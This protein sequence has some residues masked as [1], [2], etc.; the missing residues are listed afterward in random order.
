MGSPIRI[1]AERDAGAGVIR[2][3]SAVWPAIWPRVVIDVEVEIDA[4][5]FEE[6]VVQRDEANFDRHLQVLQPPQLVQ[7]IGDLFVDFLRLADDQAQVRRERLDRA[8]AADVIP[9]VG[10][11][12]AW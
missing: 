7:Q 9:G 6:V 11:D 10:C 5:P 4:D 12:G 2:H 3:G 1:Q 8:R